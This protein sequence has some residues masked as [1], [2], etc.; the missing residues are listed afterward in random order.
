MSIDFILAT[1]P[2]NL[3]QVK[4]FLIARGVAK[5]VT[6]ENGSKSVVGTLG[7]FEYTVNGIPN[8][9]VV[10]GAG[11]VADPYVYDT[12]NV[13]LFRF[14]HETEDDQI[15]GDVSTDDNFTKAKL[16]KWVKANGTPVVLSSANGWSA[17]CW[18]VTVNGV[19][20]WLTNDIGRIGVW[21]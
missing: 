20:V 5:E 1:A 10:S 9:F 2:A 15:A 4:N 11:T 18:R 21:Q 7:G 3:I 12:K 14:S 16:V 17:N 19:N 13:F 6:N 8:P